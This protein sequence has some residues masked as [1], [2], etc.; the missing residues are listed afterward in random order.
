MKILFKN[1][2]FGWILDLGVPARSK[3]QWFS[4]EIL[5]KNQIFGWILDLGIPARSKNQ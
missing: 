2:F 5:L 3:N 1:Q 4:T